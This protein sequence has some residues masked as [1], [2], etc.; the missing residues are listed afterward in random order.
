MIKHLCKLVWNRK[1]I[2]FLI[3]IEIFFSFLVLFSVIVFAVYYLNNYLYPLGFNYENIWSIQVDTR[4]GSDEKDKL[5]RLAKTNQIIS[6]LREFGE[7]ES[8]A[9]VWAAPFSRGDWTSGRKLK[10]GRDFDYSNNEASDE[11]KEVLG[12]NVVRGRWFSKE[13]DGVTNYKPV[14]IN[15]MMARAFFG[16]ED[17]IGKDISDPDDKERKEARVVGVIDD[18][19]KNGE[20]SEIRGYVFNRADFTNQQSFLP[21]F[22]LIKVRPETTAVFEEKLLAR[23]Q[24]EARDWSFTIKTL[25]DMR[26]NV[27][28]EYL[29]PMTAFALVAGFLL[30]MVG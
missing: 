22:F 4:S 16:D 1:R 6:A 27:F 28:Q 8:A 13:D 25:V 24:A 11:L 23:L 5:Q 17:P 12:L 10:D 18:F 9:A 20:F 29:V 21:R 30:I 7:V 26:A 2:N 19:R 15:Q 14:V 3:T